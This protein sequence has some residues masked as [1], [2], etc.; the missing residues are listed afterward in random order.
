MSIN[1]CNFGKAIAYIFLRVGICI[2]LLL[3]NLIVS[4]TVNHTQLYMKATGN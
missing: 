4:P 1:F 2:T 3:K